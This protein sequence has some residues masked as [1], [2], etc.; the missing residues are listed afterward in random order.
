M[1]REE[2][3][4]QKTEDRRQKTEDRRQK[5]E[6]RRQKNS[7]TEQLR[8]TVKPEITTSDERQLAL[9]SPD[10]CLLGIVAPSE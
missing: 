3:R 1:R 2:D 8:T 7:P 4:R 6:D 5:T 9:L 10:F